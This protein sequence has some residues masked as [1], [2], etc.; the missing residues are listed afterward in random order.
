MTSYVLSQTSETPT[1]MKEL[2]VILGASF[3]IT[4]FGS[5]AIPLPFTPIPLAT[6]A[7]VVLLLGALLGSRRAALAVGLF[8]IEGACGLPVFSG[9]KCGLAHLCGPTG[10]YLLGYLFGAYA[11]GWVVERAKERTQLVVFGAMALGNGVI[12]LCGF[13][14]LSLFLGPVSACLLGVL[15]FLLGDGLKLMFATQLFKRLRA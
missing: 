7:Q 11:T 1:G 14:Y 10:G 15:P 3:L 6:Q 13:A 5:V 8:L 9:G 2:L 4:L 12:F